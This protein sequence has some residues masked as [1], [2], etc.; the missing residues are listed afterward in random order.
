[1]GAH[2]FPIIEKAFSLT[3]HIILSHHVPSSCLLIF[4]DLI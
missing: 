1:L 3:S 4:Q 2:I